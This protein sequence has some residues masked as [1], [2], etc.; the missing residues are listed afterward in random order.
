MSST[1]TLILFYSNNSKACKELLN[2]M[3]SYDNFPE[4]SRVCIDNQKIRKRIIQDKKIGITKVPSIIK[5]FASTGVLELYQGQKAF[6]LIFEKI[7]QEQ[8]PQIQHPHVPQLPQRSSQLP[9]RPPQVSQL[10]QRPPQVSQLPQRPPQPP[11]VSQLPQLP[12]QI[13][14]KKVN[15][16]LN[17]T[18]IA[19]EKIGYKKNKYAKMDNSKN[20][21]DYSYDDTENANLQKEARKKMY[22]RY[23]GNKKPTSIRKDSG[24]YESVNDN[25]FGEKQERTNVRGAIKKADKISTVDILTKAKQMEKSRRNLIDSNK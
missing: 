19:D 6:D 8:P 1:F 3:D 5:F 15:F 24:N 22:E 12:Q 13:Q 20:S 14:E 4:I 7:N 2:T 9:Q 21:S 10:P 17:P 23:T 18:I 11:Q 16:D 25:F